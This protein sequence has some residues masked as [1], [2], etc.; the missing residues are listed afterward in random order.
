MAERIMCHDQYGGVRFCPGKGTS[1]A[2]QAIHA[3][4][5]HPQYGKW[6]NRAVE[7]HRG[8]LRRIWRC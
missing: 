7:E 6:A 2:F 5:D 8:Q 3:L 4:A 1:D